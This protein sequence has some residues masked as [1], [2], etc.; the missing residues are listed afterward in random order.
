MTG[1]VKYSANVPPLPCPSLVHICSSHMLYLHGGNCRDNIP[2]KRLFFNNCFSCRSASERMA[3]RLPIELIGQYQDAFQQWVNAPK[4]VWLRL[5][6]VNV[7]EINMLGL[8]L[9]RIHSILMP[10][11]FAMRRAAWRVPKWVGSCGSLARTRPTQRFRS[12]FFNSE[13]RDK[14]DLKNLKQKSGYG[15]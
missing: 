3:E 9:R 14:S 10:S 12:S 5:R 13:R 8:K 1:S 6:M 7:N 2:T 15:G 4:I 11:G